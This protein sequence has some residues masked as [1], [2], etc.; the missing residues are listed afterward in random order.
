M[1]E[2]WSRNWE[3]LGLK[4]VPFGKVLILITKSVRQD[5]KAIG[6]LIAY[7]EASTCIHNHLTKY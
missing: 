3:N 5:L 7:L 6:P 4:L 1:G 2:Q